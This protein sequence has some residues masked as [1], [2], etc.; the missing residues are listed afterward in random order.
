MSDIEKLFNINKN[1]K[2]TIK[3]KETILG[4]G[5]LYPEIEKDITIKLKD[6]DRSGHV[7]CLGTTRVGKSRLIENIVEQ[8]IRKGYNVA[9]FD[10]KGD[11]GL[12]NKT[13]QV[14]AETGR[15]NDLML[16]TPIFPEQSIM[17]DPLTY[18]YMEDELVD[19]AI[20]GIKAKD[21]FFISIAQEVTQAVVAGL[22]I[23][24]AFRGQKLK[25]NFHDIRVRS[26]YMSL[27]A[28]ADSISMLPNSEETCQS[29]EQI[30]TSPQDYFSKVS[31]SLRTTLSALTTGSTGKIIGKCKFNEFVKRFEKNEGVILFCNTGSMLARRTAHIIGR[32]LVSMIQSLV[33]RFFASGRKLDPPLCLH[34]DEGHNMLYRGIQELFNKGGGA[35]VWIHFYTQS[36]AQIEEEVGREIAKSILDN[37]NTCI[38]MLVNNPDTAKYVEDSSPDIKKFQPMIAFG[39][40]VTLRETEA[41][42]ILASNVM[43]LPKRHFY[44]RSY[45]KIYKGVTSDV[46][47]SYVNIELPQI[48]TTEEEPAEN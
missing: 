15:L 11:M 12:L 48:I 46:K 17:L 1:G 21:D 35:N 9:I 10:P 42:Q 2:G 33:G 20:S 22:A 6:E 3:S 7:A 25:I 16:L 44:M 18:Y 38:Y 47:E 8:D 4:H 29:I 36:I 34:L 37:M 23:E 19:H 41:K 45:G 40:G 5:V 28:F 32:V 30:L 31:A 13:V 14:A 26:D 43:Q 39:G 24:A 27:K